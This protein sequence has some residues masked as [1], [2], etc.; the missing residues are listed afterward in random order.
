MKIKGNDT[1]LVFASSD[2]PIGQLKLVPFSKS[3]TVAV[4]GKGKFSPSSVEI[5]VHGPKGVTYVAV[6][7]SMGIGKIDRSN[8][9]PLGDHLVASY[10]LVRLVQDKNMANMR[11]STMTCTMTVEVGDEAAPHRVTLPILHNVKALKKGDELLVFHEPVPNS[12]MPAQK[13]E[14]PTMKRPAAAPHRMQKPAEKR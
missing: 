14:R 3:I 12:G 1:K 11:K 2:Y 4:E 5:K 10:W 7:N 8:K 6:V 13:L 9:K